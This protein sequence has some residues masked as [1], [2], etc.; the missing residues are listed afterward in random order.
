MHE[1]VKCNNHVK[2]LLFCANFLRKMTKIKISDQLLCFVI[3]CTTFQSYDNP[4][5]INKLLTTL[6]YVGNNT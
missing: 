2:T 5:C 3:L 6:I 4:L 1:Y